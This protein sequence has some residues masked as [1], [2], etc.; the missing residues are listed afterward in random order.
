MRTYAKATLISDLTT[1]ITSSLLGSKT[2][3]LNQVLNLCVCFPFMTH[4]QDGAGWVHEGATNYKPIGTKLRRSE[5]RAKQYHL[6]Q[7]LLVKQVS[8]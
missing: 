4:T 5:K 7:S 6:I 8:S 2:F 1:G 3:P